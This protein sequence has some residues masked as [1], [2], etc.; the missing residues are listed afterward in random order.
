MAPTQE[1]IAAAMLAAQQKLCGPGGDF[2]LGKVTWRAGMPAAERPVT[3]VGY[4]KGPKTLRDV[5]DL[6]FA[7][8]AKKEFIVFESE[9]Y[10]FEQFWKRASALGCALKEKYGIKTGDRVGVTMQNCPEW[11]ESMTAITAIGAVCVPLNSWWKGAELEY[12]ISDAGCKLVVCDKKRYESCKGFLPFLGVRCITVRTEE[13]QADNYDKVIAE[14]KNRECPRSPVTEDDLALIMY[15]SG[16]TG[17]PKGVASTNRGVTTMLRTTMLINRIKTMLGAPMDTAIICPIPLFHVTACHHIFFASIVD[18]LKVV[19][20][21]KWD[22]GVALRLIAKEKPTKWTG[23]PTMAQDMMEHPDFATTDT[24]SLRSVGSGGA[25]TPQSQVAKT[26]KKFASAEPAQGYGL[27]ETNGAVAWNTGANFVAKPASTGPPMPTVEFLVVD[28]ETGA[29][30]PQGARG[31]LLVKSP[32]N[33]S[34]Y[35]NKAEATNESIVEIPGHGYGWFKTGDVGEIDSEGFVYIRDRAKDI[36]IRGGENISCGEVEAAFFAAHTAIHELCCFGV[37]DN[38]LGETPGLLL[39]LKPGQ[40]L[41]P[42]DLVKDMKE[43]GA[44]AHFKIPNARHV[45]FTNEPLVRGATGKILKRVI[46]DDYN[47]RLA[48]KL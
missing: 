40:K 28:V 3:G 42:V 6:K 32:L 8:N 14:Y 35:W 21:S 12:G 25:P 11:M 33:Y 10:T 30:L 20:M 34:H 4:T 19:V 43:S 38:R 22:A 29:V 7:E 13:H 31:E 36:I 47:K 1:Q 37:K 15:T 2:E 26:A 27:T 17:H 48:A 5:Y 16:T 24:S 39:F 46:R 41:D 44:L 9:R 23:V 45:F 18:G